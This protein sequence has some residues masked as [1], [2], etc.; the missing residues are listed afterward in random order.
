MHDA[1]TVTACTNPPG[2]ICAWAKGAPTNAYVEGL[3]MESA[4]GPGNTWIRAAKTF[5][6]AVYLRNG[7]W[8]AF[9]VA[10]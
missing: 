1:M 3:A 5:G 4:S 6:D 7:V 8:W 10:A 2:V 9:I